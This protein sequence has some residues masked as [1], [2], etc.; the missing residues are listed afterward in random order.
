MCGTITTAV[1]T[2]CAYDS[3]ES[4]ESSDTSCEST[5]SSDTSCAYDSTESTD[6]SVKEDITSKGSDWSSLND[7]IVTTNSVRSNEWSRETTGSNKA[8]VSSNEDVS[9][10]SSSWDDDVLTNWTE[11]GLELEDSLLCWDFLNFDFSSLE[12]GIVGY[13][14]LDILVSKILS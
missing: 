13:S 4:T 8:S 6:T 2:S 14:L 12:G 5:E 1:D 3:T 11:I 10:G 7:N 9:V